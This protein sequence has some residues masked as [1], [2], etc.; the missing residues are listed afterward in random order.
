MLACSGAQSVVSRYARLTMV[1]PQRRFRACMALLALIC[2][3]AQGWSGVLELSLY[4]T[5]AL[6]LVAL[7]LCGRYVG[8]ARILARR[9]RRAR[10]LPR[11]PRSMP[12]VASSRP[13]ASLLALSPRR[14]RGPPL[15]C[16]LT[17]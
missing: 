15:A 10:A 4:F 9:S 13:L 11:A 16:A 17:A 1:E 7:L 14:E 3:A 8:E 2:A 6:L 5:P 12:R